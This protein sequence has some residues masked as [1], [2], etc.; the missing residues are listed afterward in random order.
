[1]RMYSIILMSIFL[2]IGLKASNDEIKARGNPF[3]SPV[4]FSQNNSISIDARD[5][6]DLNE[7]LSI[8]GVDQ[9]DLGEETHAALGLSNNESFLNE[10]INVATS[11]NL[12]RKYDVVHNTKGKDLEKNKKRRIIPSVAD[13]HAS[14]PPHHIPENMPITDA[15]HIKYLRSEIPKAEEHILISSWGINPDKIS[16]CGIQ[17]LLVQAIKRGVRIYAYIGGCYDSKHMA[18]VKSISTHCSFIPVHTKIFAVD[19]DFVALG[20]FNWLNPFGV[21]PVEGSPNE[22]GSFVYRGSVSNNI[23][24][25]VWEKI[26]LYQSIYHNNT[27]NII[28]G[29]SK[30]SFYR[31][32]PIGNSKEVFLLPTGESHINF[33]SEEIKKV[34]KKVIISSFSVS[35]SIE[36]KLSDN[37]MLQALKRGVQFYFITNGEQ[38]CHR[39]RHHFDY[40][41]K[42]FKTQFIF[43][44]NPNLHSKTWIF[45]DKTIVQ[46]SYN[47]FSAAPRVNHKLSNDWSS[48]CESGLVVTGLAAQPFIQKYY[49]DSLLRFGI[50]DRVKSGFAG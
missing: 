46:T 34:E 11:L 1:M 14:Y 15:E 35:D 9:G 24:D 8:I 23:K 18:Y 42:N 39:I 16:S 32:V 20:S 44:N 30:R 37:L 13:A 2:C 43:S 38:N 49:Q 33:L 5:I 26:K 40:F 10:K 19:K 7:P 3:R 25:A 31:S 4:N 6:V 41:D 28:K 29:M 21:W 27:R 45:D 17:D 12:K 47:L 48:N 36:A 50:Q 22:N